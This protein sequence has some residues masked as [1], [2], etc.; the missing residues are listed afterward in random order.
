MSRLHP[1]FS[2]K[3]RL[4]RAN[5]PGLGLLLLIAAAAQLA[6]SVFTQWHW[7]LS[8]LT[9]ALLLGIF[10]GNAR[11]ALAQGKWRPGMLMAQKSLL[12]LGVALYGLNLSVQQL[13]QVGWAGL[14]TDVL[15]VSSTIVLGL[16][17]GTRW[18]KLDLEQALLVS[19]GSAI[20]GAAAVVATVPVLP[21]Q[22]DKT[23]AQATTAI[24]TVVL[25]GSLAMLVYPML[26]A[27]F[28]PEPAA[29]GHYVGSTVHEVA[30]VVAIGNM[31]TPEVAD[32]AVILKMLRVLL[33]VPFLLV[34]SAVI[35]RRNKRQQI[36][37]AG[38]AAQTPSN[39]TTQNTPWFAF[40]FMAL[41]VVHSY[42]PLPAAVLAALRQ[43]GSFSLVLA[44]AAFGLE[45]TVERIRKG[46][47]RALALGAALFAYL[48]I[49]GAWV[50]LH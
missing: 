21:G 7:Q 27:Y 6:F 36:H 41:I 4:F 31:T 24:A 35:S 1:Y 38:Q 40:A 23:R 19:V 45:T 16:F 26:F 34:L 25:F 47:L 49:M 15:V 30:Q 17:L 42:L 44:M 39:A 48:L 18:L 46:G 8:A 43:L 2:H 22:E 20:C 37:A 29:F 28:Q 32:N 3:L 12:R 14:A 33:L 11:P 9:L 10:A 5:L 13:L 50:N